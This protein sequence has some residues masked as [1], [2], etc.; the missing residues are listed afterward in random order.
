[1]REQNKS[2][3]WRERMPFSQAMT[4]ERALRDIKNDAGPNYRLRPG[5]KTVAKRAGAAAKI[6]RMVQGLL[7][8][9]EKGAT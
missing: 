8:R 6:A 9:L 7:K 5:D 4:V 1:M 3:Q 2:K